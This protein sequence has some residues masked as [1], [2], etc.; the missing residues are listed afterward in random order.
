MQITS[1]IKQA[2]ERES[3]STT[4]VAARAKVHRSTVT[5]ILSGKVKR[6]SRQAV[7]AIAGAVKELTA[8]NRQIRESL[9]AEGE[10]SE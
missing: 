10:A 2:V 4:D 6:P 9:A 3:L 8:E 1:T 7:A 5:R